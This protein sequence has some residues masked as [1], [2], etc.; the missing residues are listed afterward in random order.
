MTAPASPRYTIYLMREFASSFSRA[1]AH[2]F[3]IVLSL[4]GTYSP[5]FSFALRGDFSARFE[6]FHC[7]TTEV[8]KVAHLFYYGYIRYFGYYFSD[9]RV[10]GR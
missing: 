8:A 6:R 9:Y 10:D 5:A 4:L 7:A 2:F 1:T 3:R